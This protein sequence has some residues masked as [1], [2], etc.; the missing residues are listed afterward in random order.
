MSEYS[1]KEEPF[2]TDYGTDQ[3]EVKIGDPDRTIFGNHLYEITYTVKNGIASNYSDHDEIYWNVTGSGW[4]VPI[5]KARVEVKTDFGAKATDAICF[6]G[7]SGSTKK[8]CMTQLTEAGATVETTDE[9]SRQEG[10]TAV[11]GYPVESFPKSL[12]LP[13]HFISL[14]GP[15][16]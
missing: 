11:I 3:V 8:D 13:V 6:T 1:G 10:L 16:V 2:T 5:K 9:L 15:S 4:E 7:Y 14:I 12:N